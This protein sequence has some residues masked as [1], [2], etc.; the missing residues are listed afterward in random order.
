MEEDGII[1]SSMM[2]YMK[3]ESADGGLFNAVYSTKRSYR[4]RMAQIF[5]PENRFNN[6][7]LETYGDLIIWYVGPR[8]IPYIFRTRSFDATKG[9]LW[10][11]PFTEMQTN[12][13][14]NNNNPGYE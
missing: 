9:Y 7:E 8:Y 5:T 6:N 3:R 14:I 2:R 12:D 11:I 10:P 4:A 1:P 13:L